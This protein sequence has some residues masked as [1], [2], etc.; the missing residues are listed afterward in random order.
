MEA[1]LN[2]LWVLIAAVALAIWR[3]R[4]QHEQR[5]SIREPLR[6]WTA[7]GCALVLLFFAVSLTDDLHSEIVLFEE[8]ST[9]RRFTAC[10]HSSPHAGEGVTHSGPAILPADASSQCLREVGTA[11]SEEFSQWTDLS[12]DVS[13][14]RAP[15]SSSL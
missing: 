7:I 10:A 11:I 5:D 13:A 12:V 8:S 4:W 14:D 1:F 3:M 9:G 6:E 15:P 2:F